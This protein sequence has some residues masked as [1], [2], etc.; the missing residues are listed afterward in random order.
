MKIGIDARM[1]GPEN[2][3]GLGRYIQELTAAMV[4]IAPEHEFVLVVRSPD[5]P[6][7]DYPNVRT[8]VAD[9]PWYSWQEQRQMPRV[10]RDLKTDVVHIPHWNVPLTYSGPLVVTIHD[11]LLRHQPASAK[12]ST[13]SWPV[14]MIKRAGFRL[15][16]DH[17]IRVARRICVPT[18]FVQRDL[19]HLYP[20]TMGKVIVTG[21]GITTLNSKSKIQK[22]IP[23]EGRQDVRTLFVVRGQ[24]LPSQA[25]RFVI[26]SLARSL[27]ALAGHGTC[28]RR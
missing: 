22:A 15:V 7:S 21:E 6:L 4:Q 8:V 12:A 19:E 20:K 5:H 28:P 10:L 18:E 25:S 2:T 24:C 27:A 11:L 3:R 16:L 1:M 23:N 14:R 17:A 13:R 9:V 26:G